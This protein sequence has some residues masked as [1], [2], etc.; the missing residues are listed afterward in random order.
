M[1]TFI[2]P[3]ASAASVPGLIAMCQSASRAVRV[4]IGS[5]TTSLAPFFL[6]SAMNGQWCRLVLMVLQAHR[7]MYFEWRKL[8]GSMP[9]DGPMVMK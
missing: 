5:M 8:S 6:A 7:M 2:M 9:G 4:F 1:M 3:S